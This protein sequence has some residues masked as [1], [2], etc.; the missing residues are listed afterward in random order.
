MKN[1]G[2]EIELRNFE[3]IPESQLEHIFHNSIKELHRMRVQIVQEKDRETRR[4]AKE[5][6]E[7]A[8][9]AAE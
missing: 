6:E 4:L 9:Q 5:A 8:A 2:W 1:G 3:R 7:A